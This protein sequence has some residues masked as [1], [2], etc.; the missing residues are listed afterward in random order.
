MSI[1]FQVAHN[2]ENFDGIVLR[3]NLKRLKIP[4]RRIKVGI[5]FQCSMKIL[6]KEHP[7]FK[8]HRLQTCLEHFCDEGEIAVTH[9]ALQDTKDCQTI[10]ER[11]TKRIG[12]ESF[13]AYLA[14][15]SSVGHCQFILSDVM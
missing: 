12:Y 11:G 5:N 15:R 4:D 7:N 1:T 6:R 13:A 14:D 10:C 3:A 8:N 2:N 9:D